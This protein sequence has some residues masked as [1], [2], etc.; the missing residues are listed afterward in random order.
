MTL[1]TGSPVAADA[2]PTRVNALAAELEDLASRP[3]T[4]M[5]VCGGQTHAIVRWGLDQLL[6]SGMRLIHGPGCPVCVTPA[7]TVDAALALARRPEVILASYGDM[8]RVPGSDPVGGADLLGLRATG[9]DVRLLTSPL[10]ALSLAR[11]HPDRLVV[12]LAVGF[13]TTAPATAVALL[14]ARRQGIENLRVLASHV[15]VVP[16][17]EAVLSEPD[18]AIDGF[19][20]AGHV[21]A[22]MGLG[23]LQALAERHRLPVVVTGFQPEE[24]MQGVVTC[25]RL[26]EEGGCGVRNAYGA[27]VRP[28][29]NPQ[30]RSAMEA[31]FEPVSAPWRGLGTI[32][33]GALALRE[34]YRRFDAFPLL[35]PPGPTA[36]AP[37][38]NPC[39]SGR[40]LQGRALPSDC[41]A[42]GGRCRPE[43]PL[44]APMVSSEGACAAYHRYR[45]AG[46]PARCG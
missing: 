19:L 11:R 20:A 9:G 37:E 15:R 42:F 33:G 43:H 45:G 12:F 41:P 14:Q 3:W 44:G 29:G 22:V 28:D 32:T 39:I 5:E 40:I 46:I 31:V 6:P 7:A 26:L 23:E 17:M 18:C 4:L 30:A 8:L 25:V 13:E 27:V 10:E 34:D 35:D 21:A 1:L 2:P 38:D 36:A 24:L 16:A